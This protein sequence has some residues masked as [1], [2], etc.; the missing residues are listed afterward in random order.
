MPVET[1]RV[2]GLAWAPL[3]HCDLV[4]L[5]LNPGQLLICRSQ[6]MQHVASKLVWDDGSLPPLL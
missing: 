6:S 5:G 2:D 3:G 1:V 4:L